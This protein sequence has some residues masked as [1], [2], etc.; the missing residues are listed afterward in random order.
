MCIVCGKNDDTHNDHP[1]VLTVDRLKTM[2]DAAGLTP[3]QIVENLTATT[4]E[5]QAK[6]ADVSTDEVHVQL[7]KA[8]EDLEGTAAHDVK[9]G[10]KKDA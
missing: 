8:L 6:H 1:D 5:A 10:D 7:A 2:A 3:R 4:I 9:R